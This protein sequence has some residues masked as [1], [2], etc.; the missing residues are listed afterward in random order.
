MSVVT[1]VRD[2]SIPGSACTDQMS[3]RVAAHVSP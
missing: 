1:P 3:S 2:G